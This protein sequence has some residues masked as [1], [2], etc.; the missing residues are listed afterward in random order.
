MAR[1]YISTI[2]TETTRELQRLDG[3]R[4]AYARMEAVG[5]GAEGPDEVGPRE[6]D[7]IA[8]RDS[9]YMASVTADGWPYIQHRGGPPGF[10]K[11][12]DGNRFGFA[13]YRGN[14]QHV[15]EAN[16]LNDDR[17]ALFLVDYPARRRLKLI[18]NARMVAAHDA[19]DLAAQL[20]AP[21]YDALVERVCLIDIVG[22]DW[23][24][25]QHITPRYT[26][27]QIAEAV[28]P[29]HAEIE[30]LRSLLAGGGHTEA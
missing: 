12:V 17:V 11:C 20:Q 10:F 22:F 28:A 8:L 3:S 27:D 6:R 16:I 30:R 5:N 18:G 13:D 2:F 14:R 15:T 7:F 24:C 25:P 4:D 9:L 19:P 29:L 26:H 21:G 23:N 1:T